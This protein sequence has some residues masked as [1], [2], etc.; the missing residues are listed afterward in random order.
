MKLRKKD[1]VLPL[2]ETHTLVVLYKK[3]GCVQERQ[4]KINTI[5]LVKLALDPTVRHCLLRAFRLS[6]NTARAP[7]WSSSCSIGGP[8]SSSLVFFCM[9]LG[10][11]ALI[12]FSFFRLFFS[13]CVINRKLYCCVLLLN[14]RC[15]GR[16]VVALNPI[17]TDTAKRRW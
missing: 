6:N 15:S 17:Q 13:C 4:Q 11:V 5:L 9:H 8:V 2:M 12:C 16:A 1:I 7:P 3:S 10:R 14:R